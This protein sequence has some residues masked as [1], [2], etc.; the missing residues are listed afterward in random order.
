MTGKSRSA[1]RGNKRCRDESCRVKNQRRCW[2]LRDRSRQQEENRE[3]YS[4]RSP[5]ARRDAFNANNENFSDAEG[6]K[7]ATCTWQIAA[8]C[9]CNKFVTTPLSS[10]E[11]RTFH[12]DLEKAKSQRGTFIRTKMPAGKKGNKA[13]PW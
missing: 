6:N 5:F 12:P 11:A 4:Q 2:I 7:Q 8:K 3:N 1:R 9:K 10:K 13:V